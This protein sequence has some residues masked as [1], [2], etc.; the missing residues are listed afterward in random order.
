MVA[1]HDQFRGGLPR[2]TRRE[3]LAHLQ[4]HL[5]VPFYVTAGGFSLI[6][7]SACKRAVG[8]VCLLD[9]SLALGLEP[10]TAC[11]CATLIP[12]GEG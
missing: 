1:Q 5:A 8:A 12:T 3:G 9:C 11:G 2:A 4:D 10:W 6:S 7:H